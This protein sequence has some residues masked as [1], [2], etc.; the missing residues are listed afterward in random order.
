MEGWERTKG[1]WIL[2]IDEDIHFEV[3]RFT[4][5]YETSIVLYGEGISIATCAAKCSTA[6][7]RAER[8]IDSFVRFHARRIG[9]KRLTG[10]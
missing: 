9:Y 10:E 2:R 5:G 3:E 4:V 7:K 8:L 6:K 1:I